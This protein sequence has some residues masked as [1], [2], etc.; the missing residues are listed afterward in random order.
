M[1]L[2]LCKAVLGAPGINKIVPKDKDGNILKSV[3]AAC[4]ASLMLID[5]GE[6]IALY[7]IAGCAL[8]NPFCRDPPPLSYEN[9]VDSGRDKADSQ[10]RSLSADSEVTPQLQLLDHQKLS[11]MFQTA[12]RSRMLVGPGGASAAAASASTLAS[13]AAQRPDELRKQVEDALQK[14]LDANGEGNFA[15]VVRGQGASGE[16]L[17]SSESSTA[18]PTEA[19]VYV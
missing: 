18:T 4:V 2:G 15:G 3:E 12:L 1:G 16:T 8:V 14:L 13:Y 17:T 19:I 6:A 11:D 9:S 10:T 5:V 7:G